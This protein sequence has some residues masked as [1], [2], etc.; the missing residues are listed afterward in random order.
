M[1]DN[2]VASYAIRRTPSRWPS[3]T[4]VCRHRRV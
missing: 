3:R 2:Y 4:W 1:K